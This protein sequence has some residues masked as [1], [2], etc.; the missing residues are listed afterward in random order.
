MSFKLVARSAFAASLFGLV[1][2]AM[3]TPAQASV[4]AGQLSC[5]S[6]GNAGFIVFSARTFD[7]IFT[8]AAGGPAQHYQANVQRFGAQ[9]GFSDDVVLG[10]TVFALTSRVGQGALNGGYVGAS[11]GAAVGVGGSANGLV[12]GLNN[13]FALQPLS[14]QGETGLNVVAAVTGLELSGGEPVRRHR[15]HR[16]A[17]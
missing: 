9:V 4:E 12:G 11:A 15:H 17:R 3:A 13:S 16:R 1:V 2:T 6:Q 8:P 5:R 7:C 14:L 10:W